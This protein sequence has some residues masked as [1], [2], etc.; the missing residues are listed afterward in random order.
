MRTMGN[1]L[2]EMKKVSQNNSLSGE[3]IVTRQHFDTLTEAI[4]NMTRKEGGGQKSGLKLALG[5]LLKKL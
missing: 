2:A 4:Q 1:L 3:D 5:Y